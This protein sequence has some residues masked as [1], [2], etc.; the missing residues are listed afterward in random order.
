MWILW[1]KELDKDCEF[2]EAYCNRRIKFNTRSEAVKHA[3]WLMNQPYE[4]RLR[5]I[6]YNP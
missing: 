6:I 5:G 2:I 4:I 3:R 1:W